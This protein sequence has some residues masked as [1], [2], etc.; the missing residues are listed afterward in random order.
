MD[1]WAVSFALHDPLG[2]ERNLFNLIVCQKPLAKSTLNYESIP[3]KSERRQKCLL[4]FP[5]VT[6]VVEVFASTGKQGK[7]QGMRQGEY[8]V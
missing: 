2:T 6:I 3:S 8:E 1:I 5:L 7:D 4:S